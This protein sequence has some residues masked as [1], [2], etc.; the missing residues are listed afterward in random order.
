MPAF[1]P[2]SDRRMSQS[3]GCGVR[4]R[5]GGWAA[6]PPLTILTRL[7]ERVADSYSPPGVDAGS[8]GRTDSG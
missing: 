1:G 5:E 8:N 6:S 3:H 2:A 7:P 4:D